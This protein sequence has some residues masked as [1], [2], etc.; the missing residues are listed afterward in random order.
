[1]KTAKILFF[2]AV[3][4]VTAAANF[5]VGIFEPEISRDVALRQFEADDAARQQMRALHSSRQ[6]VLYAL[7]ASVPIAFVALFGS[8]ILAGMFGNQKQG[9]E[10]E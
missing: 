9:D 8:E 1:M 2:A 5:G 3:L 6:T 10:I 7:D 4:L